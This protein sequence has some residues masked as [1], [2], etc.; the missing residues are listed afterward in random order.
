MTLED[1]L[2]C[3]TLPVPVLGA[4]F[5]GLSCNSSYEA[6]KRGDIITMRIGRKIVAPV[7]PNAKKLGLSVAF[8][9]EEAA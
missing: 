9:S 4:L 6:A 2:K 3:P 8:A 1:A 7:A 5:Y